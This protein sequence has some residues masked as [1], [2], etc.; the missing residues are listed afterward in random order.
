MKKKEQESHVAEKGKSYG[1]NILAAAGLE[2]VKGAA[3]AEALQQGNGQINVGCT[4][5]VVWDCFGFA[6]PVE[7][8]VFDSLFCSI[9]FSVCMQLI[10]CCCALD[11]R[12]GCCSINPVF[13]N[14]FGDE[15][16]GL[17]NLTVNFQ[18]F[19][20]ILVVSVFES[21]I[22]SKCCWVGLLR[23]ACSVFSALRW[24]SVASLV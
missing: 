19:A 24:N 9:I 20:L 14:W 23:C 7:Q 6:F 16:N 17:C 4:R 13:N 5:D 21:V 22:M 12:S 15:F 1:Y 10:Y 3:A 8:S 2:V 11:D 18:G